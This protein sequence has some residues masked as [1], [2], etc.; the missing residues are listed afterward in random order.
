MEKKTKVVVVG[1]TGYLGQHLLQALAGDRYDVAFTHHSCPLPGL[2]LDAFP[3]F[4]S[5]HVDLETG[6]GFHSI[7][8]HF[9]QVRRIHYPFFLRISSQIQRTN[10]CVRD[11]LVWNRQFVSSPT[12]S[13]IVQLSLF[14]ESVSKIQIQLS[15]S[16]SLLPLLTGYH[17]LFRQKTKPCWFISL[18]IKVNKSYIER[19]YQTH[20]SFLSF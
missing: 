20:P 8:H 6:L 7:S 4:P 16:T 12:W 14:L 13:W 15:P 18:L 2:L 17:H 19:F 1:G 3:H 11:P 5:F 10:V 9:G